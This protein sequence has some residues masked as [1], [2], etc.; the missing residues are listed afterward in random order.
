MTIKRNTLREAIKIS[1]CI[2]ATSMLGVGAAYAQDATPATGSAADAKAKNLDTVTVTG[3][4]VR[5][6][7]TETA[8]PVISLD[9]KAIDATGKLTIGEIVNNLATISGAPATTEVNNGG[10]TGAATAEL[11]GLGSVRTLVLID[12]R[13]PGPSPVDLNT[14]P[15]ELVERIDIET[16]GASTVYGSDAV[17]GVINFIMKKNYSGAQASV[18]YG[19]S[20]QGDG[21]RQGVSVM[22]GQ[23]GEKGNFAAGVEY[24]KFQAVPAAN[25][26]FSRNSISLSYGSKV[27]GGSSRTPTGA[28]S[29]PANLQ[30]SGPGQFNCS[31]VTLSNGS[32]GSLGNYRCFNNSTDLFNFAP[33][34][35]IL[36]P[37]ERTNAFALGTFD[38]TENVSA[39]IQFYHQKQTAQA[40]LA[41]LP[42][43][44]QSDG[45]VISANSY[46][47]PFG[48]NFGP[49]QNADTSPAQEFRS[50]FTT[51]GQRV[52]NNTDNN[53]TLFFGFK[54][55]VG[56]TWNWD[57]D[58]SYNHFSSTAAPS[59][60]VNYGALRQALGPSFKDPVTGVITCGTL[61]AP[62]AN[63]TPLNIFNVSD[64]ATIAA[65]Q[66]VSAQP[67]STILGIQKELEFN[68]NGDLF[69]L[70]AGPVQLA[71]G[72]DRIDEYQHNLVDPLATTTDPLTGACPLAQE[73]C[74]TPLAGGYQVNEVYAEALIPIMKNVPGIY[75]LNLDLGDR[76]SKYSAFGSTNNA[77]I[78]IEYRPIKDLLLR[79][80]ATDIFRAPTVANVFGGAA[81]NAP[82]LQSDLCTGFGPGNNYGGHENFCGPARGTIN[83]DVPVGGI[84][85]ST[86]S[87]QTTGVIEGSD[88][89]GVNLKPETGRSYNFGFVYDPEFVPGLSTTVDFYR[90]NL[91]DVIQPLGATTIE[92]ACFAN[93][94]SDFCRFVHRNVDGSLNFITQPTFN[95]GSETTDGFDISAK[96]KI[97]TNSFG[98]FTLGTDLTHINKFDVIVDPTAVGV[99]PLHLAGHFNKDFGNYAKWRGNFS[100]DWSKG[101]FNVTWN[102]RWVGKLQVGDADPGQNTSADACTGCGITVLPIGN[103]FDSGITAGYNIKAYNSRVDVGVDNV[104]D[105]QP[106]FFYAN[107]TLNANTDVNN[108]DTLG[109]FFFGR[110]TVKF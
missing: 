69:D 33:Q 81:G 7:E 25:R 21:E 56:Q 19:V 37:Q 43:D 5:R 84:Q 79:A 54:G 8:S 77:K 50:R 6:V 90:I 57:L 30:G 38:I 67:I 12:G 15:L 82:P 78:A 106:P 11:R 52:F 107:N 70:P 29:L 101:D 44:A 100:I 1:L 91:Q 102:T 94:A 46:Y 96:Y 71:F 65:L 72:G 62:I 97:P 14:I 83:G 105:K 34:N 47:N 88:L 40:Q 60:Y 39:F 17:A 86:T 89:A 10:G 110:F 98:V 99:E 48:T 45:V 27:I 24:N 58:F 103:Y 22:G 104:F 109:R 28:I 55:A 76:Y 35:I 18:N 64:P 74:S 31:K 93:D 36:Q 95:L 9:R 42:F 87:G 13:R 59:G 53:D 26:A 80:S 68:A 23:S 63:C 16:T 49:G 61:A 92:S 3:S 66:A 73:V 75:S 85:N 108:Y 20:G 32:G 41:P 51:L 2:G 4:R